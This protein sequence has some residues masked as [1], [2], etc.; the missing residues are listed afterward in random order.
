MRTPLAHIP[1]SLRHALVEIIRLSAKSHEEDG[2]FQAFA[3][4][5]PQNVSKVEAAFTEEMKRALDG[6]FTQKELDDDRTGWLQ[7]QQVNRSEDNSLVRMLTSRDYDGRT[8]AWDEEIEK[9]VTALTP[10]DIGKAV[11]RNIDLAQVS[12]VKAGDFKKA[13]AAK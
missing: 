7:G 9:K 11:R 3:I 4:A 5:A 2:E 10:D 1:V 6:G 8:M 13:A 12:I